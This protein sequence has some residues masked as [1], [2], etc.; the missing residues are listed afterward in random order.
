MKIVNVVRSLEDLIKLGRLKSDNGKYMLL[1]NFDT[2]GSCEYI[3]VDIFSELFKDTFI[4]LADN[5][6]KE[7]FTDNNIKSIVDVLSDLS[8][9]VQYQ[10]DNAENIIDDLCKIVDCMEEEDIK[11]YLDSLK[12]VISRIE[13]LK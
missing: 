7:F 1:F 8:F 2:N 9:N 3:S 5:Q 13:N 11:G 4:T 10:D 6:N 12:K